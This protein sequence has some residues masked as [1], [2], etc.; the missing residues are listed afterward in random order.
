MYG[1][2]SEEGRGDGILGDDEG[3]GGRRRAKGGMLFSFTHTRRRCGLRSN[4]PPS[5]AVSTTATA[6][7]DSASISDPAAKTCLLAMFCLSSSAT[8]QRYD[9]TSLRGIQPNTC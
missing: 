9:C 8:R 4:L 6:R 2:R 5:L 1:K 7:L 3:K